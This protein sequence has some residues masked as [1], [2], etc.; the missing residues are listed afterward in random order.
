MIAQDFLLGTAQRGAHRGN[1]GDN[2][3]AVPIV[4]DHPAKAAN[5]AFDPV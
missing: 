2:I 4:L 1:L 3:D 5:L